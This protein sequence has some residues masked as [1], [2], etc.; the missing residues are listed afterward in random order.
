MGHCQFSRWKGV[1]LSGEF[2][3]RL[4]EST[5]TAIRE[6]AKRQGRS[7]RAVIEEVIRLYV[8]ADAAERND[9]TM[10]PLIYRLL[11]EQHHQLGKG[12]RSLMVRVGHEVMRTQFVLYNFMVTAGMGE[13]QVERW[14]EDG[15]RYATK[16]FKQR[17]L[18]GEEPATEE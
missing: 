15:W 18:E 10:A 3:L 7:Q 14:R 1:I 11:Q 8:L 9:A 6:I 12:F 17:P 2:H 16:E 5:T 4:D 13:A